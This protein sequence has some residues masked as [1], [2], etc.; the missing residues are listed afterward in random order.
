MASDNCFCFIY[1]YII[2]INFPDKL[3]FRY[4]N[5]YGTSDL[6]RYLV[7]LQ[8]LQAVSF[9]VVIVRQ[10]LF[11]NSYNYFDYM[12]LNKPK[13]KTYHQSFDKSSGISL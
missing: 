12:Y 4:N 8:Q 7:S 1:I 10:I 3:D 9:F 6:S 5:A 2:I 11:D 13:D